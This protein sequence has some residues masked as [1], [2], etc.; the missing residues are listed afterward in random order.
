VRARART[1]TR[2][3]T[4]PN[5]H[6]PLRNITP[7]WRVHRHPPPPARRSSRLS[8]RAHRP[9]S[10]GVGGG[11]GVRRVGVGVR[12]GELPRELWGRRE[13]F[14]ACSRC[15]GATFDCTSTDIEAVSICSPIAKQASQPA[16]L[17]QNP[18]NYAALWAIEISSKTSPFDS[19]GHFRIRARAHRPSPPR[20]S[21]P[22]CMPAGTGLLEAD[23]SPARPESTVQ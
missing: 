12:R 6:N 7:A 14:C 1:H 16:S 22:T 3:H 20:R 17:C 11:V 21:L 10:G 23:D 19:A 5:T 9:L 2:T 18:C 15:S 4:E 13:C 8:V